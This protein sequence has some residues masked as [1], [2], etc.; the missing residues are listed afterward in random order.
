MIKLIN[1]KKFEKFIVEYNEKITHTVYE[2]YNEE[3][4][5]CE[6]LLII[7]NT[8]NNKILNHKHHRWTFN[9]RNLPIGTEGI[10]ILCYENEIVT[11]IY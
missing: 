6:Q 8:S 7:P 3:N 11:D 4:G 10:S 1:I 2:I 9:T 5:W